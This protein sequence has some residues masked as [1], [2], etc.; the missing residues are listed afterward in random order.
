M[1]TILASARIG[2]R[3]GTRVGQAQRVIQFA[4][5]Q[6]PGIGG[7]RGAAEL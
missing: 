1:T 5:G 7:E 3:I 6:Q 4:I 2:K